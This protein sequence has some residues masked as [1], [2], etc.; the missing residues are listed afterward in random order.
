MPARTHQHPERKASLWWGATLA[1]MF[2]ATAPPSAAQDRNVLFQQTPDTIVLTDAAPT[3]SFTLTSLVPQ[4][5]DIW[6][7]PECPA[8]SYLILPAD[9]I[10]DAWHNQSDCAIPWLSD[11]PRHFTLAAH[12]RRTLSVRI[13]PPPTL[14]HG[15]YVGRLIWA[16][17]TIVTTNQDSIRSHFPATPVP[18]AEWSIYHDEFDVTYD[19]GPHPAPH[20]PLQRLRMHWSPTL[21]PGHAVATITHTPTV[22]VLDDHTHSTT[23]TLTNPAATPTDIWLA[24]DCPWFQ[25]NF[26]HYPISHQY[27]SAWHGRIPNASLWLADFP[28]HLTL[29]PHERRTL[30]LHAFS[31]IGLDLPT[32][33]YYARLVIAR[34]PIAWATPAHDTLYA[35]PHDAIP[36]VYHRGPSIPALTLSHLQTTPHP[37]GTSQAC[38]RMQQP[39]I[40]FIA[41]LHAEVDDAQRHPVSPH[42]QSGQGSAWTLDTT[43]TVWEVVHHNP[44]QAGQDEERT[45][46]DPVCF[47]LPPFPPGHKDLVLSAVALEDTAHAHPVRATFPLEGP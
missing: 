32:G 37:D 10:A 21:P 38:V 8:S 7:A 11:Y 22:L 2:A 30:T 17:Y 28:Q 16:I 26:V 44:M 45:D 25:V 5:M 23:V 12:E 3:A 27:E 9:P 18:T 13:T 40:G 20:A 24:V 14:P 35:T 46:P 4:D 47:S 15:H 29:A 39:G 42:S 33:T 1:A 34:S 41:L 36:V 6:L 31:D 19:H 43:V